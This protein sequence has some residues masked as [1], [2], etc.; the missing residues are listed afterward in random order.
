MYPQAVKDARTKFAL[1]RKTAGALRNVQTV[2]CPPLIY[3]GDLSKLV[4]G[5]RCVLGAQNT[6]IENEG[7]FTGE[8]SP[9]MIVSMGIQ[10]VIV[11]HSERRAMGETD[12]L[13]N[14]KILAAVKVGLKVVLCVGESERDLDGE[15]L[16]LIAAQLR[17][18]LKN[19]QKKDLSNVVIAYEP[20]WAIGKNALRAATPEDALE[21]SISIKKTLADLYG[22]TASEV[23]VLYGGSVD[24]KNSREFLSRS[25]VSGLLVG[26][27][28][29][30]IGVFTSI[31]KSANDIK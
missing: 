12:E 16:K 15:Y 18:G 8:V 17:A 23:L 9:A 28:S 4:S 6:W 10:Y 1:I 19:I 2:V 11:G 22:S 25:Q 24:A 31:L 20:I 26:R 27:A 7:A 13:V 5:H 30:D 14:K 29:L 3:S 21:V